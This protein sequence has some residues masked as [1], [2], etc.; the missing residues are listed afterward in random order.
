MWQSSHKKY[1]K[2]RF[3]YVILTFYIELNSFLWTNVYI[4]LDNIS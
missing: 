4:V 1:L 3:L 2:A